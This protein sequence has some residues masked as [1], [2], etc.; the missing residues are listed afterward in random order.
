[1]YVC[2]YLSVSAYLA[3]SLLAVSRGSSYISSS[4]PPVR[5]VPPN[6]IVMVLVMGVVIMIMIMI[7]MISYTLIHTSLSL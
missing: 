5:K 6:K 7:M 1:M 3:L 2:I 4:F